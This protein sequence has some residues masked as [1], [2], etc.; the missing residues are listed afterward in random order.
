MCTPLVSKP[1]FRGF[2]FVGAAVLNIPVWKHLGVDMSP[3]SFGLIRV[4]MTAHATAPDIS[5]EIIRRP[6]IGVRARK[7]KQVHPAMTA[8][9]MLVTGRSVSYAN[10]G[11]TGATAPDTAMGT[12]G[13]FRTI[14]MRDSVIAPLAAKVAK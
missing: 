1:V 14:A 9:H 4:H 12:T 10:T 5:V 8:M 3:N 11:N 13:H 7:A 2:H 6:A